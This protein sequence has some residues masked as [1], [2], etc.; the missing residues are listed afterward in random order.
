MTVVGSSVN[1]A[2]KQFFTAKVGAAQ[3]AKGTVVAMASASTDLSGAATGPPTDDPGDGS[4]VV[5]CT[6]ALVP[7]GVAMEDG[8]RG[9]IIRVQYHGFCDYVNTFGAVTEGNVLYV[10]FTGLL[11]G[12]SMG[13]VEG[14]SQIV[15]QALDDAASGVL[16]KAWISF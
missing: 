14:V 6:T 13:S 5:Y 3:M 11:G 9:D 8:T 10:A 2:I 12:D 15:G 1:Q 7:C 16:S 4:T